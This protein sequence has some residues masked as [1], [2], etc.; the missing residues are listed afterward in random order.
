[1]RVSQIKTVNYIIKHDFEQDVPYYVRL[2]NS[3]SFDEVYNPKIA[4]QFNTKKAAKE[5]I[6]TYS[7][8]ASHS[9]I[10]ESGETVN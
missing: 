4:T 3:E 8:M 9:K 6:D 1:M 2:V 5:W 10:V 7:S